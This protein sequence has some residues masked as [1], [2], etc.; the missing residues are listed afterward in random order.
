M[1][2]TKID[3]KK[4]VNHLLYTNAHELAKDCE[5]WGKTES[6]SIH[7]WIE[8]FET[9]DSMIVNSDGY[10]LSVSTSGSNYLK[11]DNNA[12]LADIQAWAEKEKVR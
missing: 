3:K 1:R 4:F 12:V 9:T 10:K 2:T 6:F 11:L 5:R 8:L 7:F